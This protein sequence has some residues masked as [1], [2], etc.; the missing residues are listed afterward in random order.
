M[1]IL[2]SLLDKTAGVFSAPQCFPNDLV[3]KRA[4]RMTVNSGDGSTLATFPED[5]AIYKIGEFDPATGKITSYDVPE[6]LF[7]A[8]DCKEV[9]NA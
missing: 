4:V 5:C 2:V 1:S 8:L 7:N 6:F 3:M 9:K